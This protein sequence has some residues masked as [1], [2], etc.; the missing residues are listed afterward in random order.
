MGPMIVCPVTVAHHRKL[1]AW[2]TPNIVGIIA[3]LDRAAGENPSR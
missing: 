3:E 1:I 2:I